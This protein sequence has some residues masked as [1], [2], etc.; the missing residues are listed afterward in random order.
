MDIFLKKFRKKFLENTWRP[1]LLWYLS[2]ERFYRYRSLSLIIFPGVFHPGFFFSTKIFL[3][4]LERIPVAGKKV[5][6]LGTGS[7]LISLAIA[8]RGG[9]AYASDIS[10]L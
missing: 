4:Y 1:F 8:K 5:L 2:K 9:M 7:G 10:Q 3:E 6:E